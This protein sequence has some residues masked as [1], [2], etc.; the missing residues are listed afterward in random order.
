MV[1][2][3]KREGRRAFTIGEVADMFGLSLDSVKRAAKRGDLKTI[4]FGGRRLV[5]LTE[6]ERV[7]RDGLGSTRMPEE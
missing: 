4:R 3:G 2:I 1:Q 6:I 7:E 5:P